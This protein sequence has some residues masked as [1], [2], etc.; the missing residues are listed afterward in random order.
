MT[1]TLP[2]L[3]FLSFGLELPA[4]RLRAN[5]SNAPAVDRKRHAVTRLISAAARFFASN[6]P[7]AEPGQQ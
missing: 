5:P 7:E 3:I 6:Q 1:K 2:V 4:Q